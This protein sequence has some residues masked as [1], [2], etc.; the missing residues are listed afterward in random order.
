MRNLYKH[1]NEPRW[2]VCS[3][4]HLDHPDIL[5]HN[6]I[7]RPFKTLDEMHEFIVGEWNS[8]VRK[9]DYVVIVG[10]FAFRNVEKWARL[11]H[12]KKY[13]IL[14]DHDSVNL[15]N[16]KLFL[17]VCEGLR[18]TIFGRKIYFHHY[19]CLTWPD[20]YDGGCHAHGHSHARLEENEYDR[21]ID[22]SMD[23]W[24][25]RII[26]IEILFEKFDSKRPPPQLTEKEREE[27][28]ERKRLLI[29]GNIALLDRY[30]KDIRSPII[31]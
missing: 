5:V 11:L 12:G 17:K 19:P 15:E 31:Q 29:Q 13:L 8:T 27:K 30:Y 16:Q 2:F 22:V 21:R 20:R 26:P 14:G 18:K 28:D 24:G 25:L 10:D 3:D 9:N 4:P 23:G 6:P 7:T 1:H